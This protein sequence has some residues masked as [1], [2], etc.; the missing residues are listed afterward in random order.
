MTQ[1]VIRT[2]FSIDSFSFNKNRESEFMKINELF[3]PALFD[4]VKFLGAS[5]LPQWLL[6]IL[7]ISLVIFVFFICYSHN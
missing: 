3:E 5:L 1:N 4:N 2:T 6:D 7:P